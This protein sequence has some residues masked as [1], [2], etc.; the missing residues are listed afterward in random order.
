MH[1]HS[2]TTPPPPTPQ[3]PVT[4]TQPRS[5][6]ALEMLIPINRSIW[7]IAAGYLGLFAIIPPMNLVAIVISGIALY[8]FS[9]H[10]E[11]HGRGR[12]IFGL[13]MG[14]LMTLVWGAILL[15]AGL[16]Y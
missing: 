14:I 2:N 3:A 1:E 7:S 15:A 8:D 6:R 4:V 13:V 12:A 16:G 11:K 10:P 5:D 9:K